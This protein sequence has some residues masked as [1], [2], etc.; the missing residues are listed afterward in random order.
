MTNEHQSVN[1]ARRLAPTIRAGLRLVGF[2]AL[3]LVLTRGRFLESWYIGA[4]AVILATWASFWVAPI[5][6]DGV[7][8]TR[9]ALRPWGLLRFV[10]FFVRRSVLGAVDV[11]RRAFSPSRPLA[12]QLVEHRLR[13]PDESSTAIALAGVI[14]LLPGTLCAGLG[15]SCV[16]VHVI[17]Q[18]WPIHD[19]LDELEERLAAVFGEPIDNS[20]QDRA[21][22]DNDRRGGGT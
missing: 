8:T 15:R 14:S 2:V 18:S 21:Q 12:P 3:W 20:R 16:T 7:S 19:Q 6:T 4:A 10:P 9:Q 5:S 22:P 11:A 1:E 13:V 17:D